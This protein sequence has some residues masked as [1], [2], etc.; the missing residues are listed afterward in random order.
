MS[1]DHIT[2]YAIFPAMEELIGRMPLNDLLI[3]SGFITT[4][5]GVHANA[6]VQ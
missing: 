5:M 6:L 2:Q 3:L 1:N 4:C